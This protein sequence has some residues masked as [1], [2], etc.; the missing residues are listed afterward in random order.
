[1]AVKGHY[2][3]SWACH[4][5]KLLS[6]CGINPA[7]LPHLAQGSLIVVLSIK[8][9][10][11]LR[12]ALDKCSRPVYANMVHMTLSTQRIGHISNS[13]KLEGKSSRIKVK[14]MLN[15]HLLLC[16]L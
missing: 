7:E 2:D 11:E 3:E 15:S 5:P 4:V 16:L 9:N 10:F 6:G 14:Y 8:L 1:M 12:L 13:S